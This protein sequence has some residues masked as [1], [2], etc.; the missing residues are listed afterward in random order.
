M[1]QHVRWLGTSI[2]VVI[3]IADLS[4]KA[5]MIPY[6]TE[7]GGLVE[8][9]PFVDLRLGYNRGVSFGLLSSNSEWAPW[10]LAF[11][12]FIV[13][14]YLAMRLWRATYKHD[15]LWAGLIIGGALGNAI[16]RLIDGVVTDFI[17]IHVLGFHWPTFNLADIAIVLGL[18]IVMLKGMRPSEKQ[19]V[20]NQDTIG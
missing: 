5:T 7:S 20:A 16:D 14:A 6:L 8:L 1:T 19:I 10:A 12:A 11:I 15:A 13:S 3:L 18:S 9:L 2:A 17:D 4:T